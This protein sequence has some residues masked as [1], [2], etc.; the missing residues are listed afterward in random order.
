MDNSFASVHPELICEW[1]DK[2]A[3]LTPAQIT[4][5]SKKLYWWK[6]TCGHEWQTS[7]KARSSG[8]KCPICSNARIIPGVNDLKTLEPELAKEWSEKNYPLKPS[9]VGPGTH[10]K[11]LWRGKCG[12][13]WSA[14]VRNRVKGAGCPY[15]SHNIVLPGFNDLESSNPQLAAEWSEKNLPLLPSQVTAYANR[16]VWWKCCF[17]NTRC[18]RFV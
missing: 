3:P 4:Y 8:E 16:K 6:G 7:A 11:V 5:G 14:V 17:N 10:K 2:N 12:H 13:E 15:C 18:I 9:Q 1:S